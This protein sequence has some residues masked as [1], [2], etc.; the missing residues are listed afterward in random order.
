LFMKIWGL[1]ALISL[2]AS[3]SY[4]A[5]VSGIVW[6][7]VSA[8]PLVAC[9]VEVNTTPLQRDITGPDGS[10]SFQLEPGSYKMAVKK[11]NDKREL[12]EVLTQN[13]DISSD[14]AYKVDLVVLYPDLDIVDIGNFSD[15]EPLQIPEQKPISPQFS[16]LLALSL[17][18]LATLA[19]ATIAF[20]LFFRK[21]KEGAIAEKKKPGQ[22]MPAA[23][24]ASK[25]LPAKLTS[26]KR[27]TLPKDLKQ[28]VSILKRNE[29]R[30]NQKDLRKEIP[31]S[32]AKVSLMITELEDLGLVKRIKKGRGNVL[33]LK[34][35]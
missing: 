4:S 16:P 5:T 10:Y 24:L 35:L 20:L 12:E 14:G 31:L 13:L 7:S 29:G 15:F 8:G 34:E 17:F 23:N 30:M 32:E 26:T 28:V 18:F 6:D 25:P 27:S 9:A 2:F 33:V 11:V 19:L 1:L 22:G 21:E 3:L